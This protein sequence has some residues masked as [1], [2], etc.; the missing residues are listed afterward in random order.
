MRRSEADLP[1]I[2]QT[3]SSIG[4]PTLFSAHVN[5][6]CRIGAMPRTSGCRADG[7][8]HGQAGLYVMDGSLLPTA[9]GVNPHETTKDGKVTLRTAE[10]LASCGTAPMMQV[11]KKYHENLTAA[12]V[13]R[14]LDRLLVES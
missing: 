8:V 1:L 6:T 14:I 12:E 3:N 9:P 11:D 4:D 13:D 5:G 2:R 7:Q 10:C